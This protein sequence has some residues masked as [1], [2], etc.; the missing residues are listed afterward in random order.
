MQMEGQSVLK[1]FNE[2]GQTWEDPSEDLLFM[3]VEDI[4]RGDEKFLLVERLADAT[5]QTY[6]QS[7]RNDDGTY[8]VE[9]RDGSPR[10]H[11]GTNVDGMRSAHALMAAWAF[12]CPTGVNPPRGAGSIS[13]AEE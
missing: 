8:V 13:K 7:A 4:E 9:Y 10:E 5:P 6:I 12:S 11:F 3:L 1:A 2:S